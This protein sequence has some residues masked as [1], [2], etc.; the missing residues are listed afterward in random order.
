[1]STT[2]ISPTIPSF[3]QTQE[4]LRAL[5][6]DISASDHRPDAEGTFEVRSR[7]GRCW[8]WFDSML[9]FWTWWMRVVAQEINSYR[10]VRTFVEEFRNAEP[11]RRRAMVKMAEGFYTRSN[12]ELIEWTQRISFVDASNLPQDWERELME[13]WT[14]EFEGLDPAACVVP[15][16]AAEDAFARE[17]FQ[18]FARS[19]GLSADA[20]V[21]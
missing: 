19:I 18:C 16:L 10:Y 5:G 17:H 12:A 7:A 20:L 9:E 21:D 13:Y 1:M 14:G 15:L 8:G 6:M 4:H 3:A 2:Y 11:E